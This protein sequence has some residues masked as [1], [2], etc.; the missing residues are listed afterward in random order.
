MINGQ[1]S[2]GEI[3]DLHRQSQAETVL[4]QEDFAAEHAPSRAG[5]GGESFGQ[6]GDR[7]FGARLV[8]AGWAVAENFRRDA[9]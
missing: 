9:H 6:C 5:F 1:P 8:G 4:R 3:A 2:V 7:G